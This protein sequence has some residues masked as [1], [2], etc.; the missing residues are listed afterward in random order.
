LAK[1]WPLASGQKAPGIC[2]DTSVVGE[3]PVWTEKQKRK[4]TAG[5]D[6][7]TMPF[8]NGWFSESEVLWPGQRFSL[9][10]KGTKA[11]VD[12]K[13][14]YQHIQIFDSETYGRVLVLDGVIQLTER[15][16]HAYQESIAH[17]PLFAHPN[18]KSVLII[19]GGYGGVLREVA[20]HSSVQKISM[21][22]IDEELVGLTKKH[23]SQSTATAFGDARLDLRFMDAAEFVRDKDE[24]FDVIIVDSSD[25]VGPA[26]TLYTSEFYQSL[27]QS[28]RPGGVICTQG[29]CMWL[30]LDLISRVMGDCAKL[31]SAVD[32]AFAAVPTYPSGQIGFVLARKA[33]CAEGA[34][35]SKPRREPPE[36][37]Q[38]LLR[39]YSPAVH[40]A[41][42][43]LPVFAEKIIAPRRRYDDAKE[44]KKRKM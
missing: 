2:K 12:C 10:V 3:S 28:L 1:P 42:F 30:H 18:P 34:R 19:G 25:P 9:K 35:L 21:C 23:F 17:I 26:E 39:Y 22:E 6:R 44:N 5:R 36:A 7:S 8:C 29:E 14:K 37:M 27:R 33:G 11:I 43:V 40:E 20:R 38:K 24:E 15:D 32:Y 41:A 31:F 16:E 13:S 4:K